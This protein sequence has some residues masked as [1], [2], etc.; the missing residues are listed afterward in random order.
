MNAIDMKPTAGL[1]RAMLLVAAFAA[2]WAVVEV[3]AQHV[4][5]RYSPYQ[6]VWTRYVIHVALMFAVWGWHDPASLWRTKRPVFQLARSLLMLA[7]PASWVIGMQQGV[8]P[9]T[10]L[11]EFWSSPLLVMALAAL[12][13]HEAVPAGAWIAGLA[14]FAGALILHPP[15]PLAAPHHYLYPLAMAASFSA[16]VVMTRSLRTESPRANLFY[17]AIGVMAVLTPA[18]PA[19]WVTPAAP[20]LLVMGAIGVVGFL[21]LWA[22]DS[23]AH[24]APITVAAPFMYVQLVLF[25]AFAFVAGGGTPG[26]PRRAVVGLLL[27]VGACIYLWACESRPHLPDDASQ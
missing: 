24:L 12:F 6:V 4:L 13:L 8:D 7:M 19:V 26:S 21:T 1:H 3:I 16:Y 18:M 17:T 2:L 5:Q 27:I 14:A 20:D 9:E 10:L 22:L 11:A 25:S 23:A 15:A